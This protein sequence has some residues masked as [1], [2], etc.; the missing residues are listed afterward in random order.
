SPGDPPQHPEPQDDGIQTGPPPRAQPLER[1]W[2]KRREPPRETPKEET[3]YN[4]K[5]KRGPESNSRP[6]DLSLENVNYCGFGA[7]LWTGFFTGGF[8]FGRSSTLTLLFSRW[9][10][11]AGSGS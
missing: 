6:L 2:P 11:N 10:M 3:Q 9:I 1:H 8:S 7:G 4:S 5:E